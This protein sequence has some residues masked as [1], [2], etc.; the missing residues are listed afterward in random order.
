MKGQGGGTFVFTCPECKEALEINDPMKNT[1]IKK[2]CVICGTPV[3][4]EAFT[5]D[6]SLDSS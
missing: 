6:S 1:L 2:G 3:T 5:E 4:E